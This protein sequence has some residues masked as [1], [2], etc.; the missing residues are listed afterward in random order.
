LGANNSHRRLTGVF[1][2]AVLIRRLGVCETAD[3][4]LI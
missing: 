2:S 1:R 4:V 3:A